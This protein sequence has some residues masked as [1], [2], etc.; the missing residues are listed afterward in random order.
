[1]NNKF[2]F[3]F[4]FR[5]AL[6]FVILQRKAR[7]IFTFVADVVSDLFHMSSVYCYQRDGDALGTLYGFIWLHTAIEC[8]MD[9]R[10]LRR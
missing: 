8:N 9:F 5:I 10:A 7:G 2:A 3:N 4:I 1:V 6:V